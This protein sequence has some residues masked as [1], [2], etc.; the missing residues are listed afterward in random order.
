MENT[1]DVQ[2]LTNILECYVSLAKSRRTQP[3]SP[4]IVNKSCCCTLQSGLVEKRKLW[5]EDVE[6][7]CTVMYQ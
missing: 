6:I 5:S 4:T 7:T 2:M 1:K 3:V